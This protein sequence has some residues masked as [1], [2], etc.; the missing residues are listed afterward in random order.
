M[1]S[2]QPLLGRVETLVARLE[3]LATKAEAGKDLRW[4]IM[5]VREIRETLALIGKLNGEIAPAGQGVHVNVGV[6]VTASHS[7]HELSGH[8]LEVQIAEEVSAATSGFDPATIA[9]LRRLAMRSR[10]ALTM[11]V[12]AAS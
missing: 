7:T 10:P 8:D 3:S 12:D 4:A 5:A 1:S 9:R 6:N 11:D 2:E